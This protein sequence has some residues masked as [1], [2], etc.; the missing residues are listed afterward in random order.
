MKISRQFIRHSSILIFAGII[1]FLANAVWHPWEPRY[2]GKRLSAWVDDLP[3]IDDGWWIGQIEQEMQP[4]NRQAAEAIRQIGAKALPLALSYCAAHDSSL[5]EKLK[6]WINQQKTLDFNLWSDY[7]Y[8]LRGIAIFQVLGSTGKPAIPI[9]LQR[10]ASKD[11]KTVNIATIALFYISPESVPPLIAALTSAN[12]QVRS[13]AA[14]TLANFETQ[15]SAAVPDL[16]RCLRDKNPR[17]RS[18]AA[19]SLGGVGGDPNVIVPALLICLKDED[20]STRNMA[21]CSLESFTSSRSK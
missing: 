12:D 7:D 4:T 18:N 15:A 5:M 6:D 8:Q 11:A 10:L 21:A 16:I 2:Q 14:M 9:L 20:S 19:G 13:T 17:V 1:L 3:V